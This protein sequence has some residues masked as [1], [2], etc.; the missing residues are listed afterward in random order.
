MSIF[1]IIVCII[2]GLGAGF[3]TGTIGLSAA[4]IITPMLV[5]FLGYPAYQ[6]VAISLASDVLASAISAYTYSKNDNINYKTA[7]LML[8]AILIATTVGSW[9]SS[10]FPSYALGNF[11]VMTTL[12]I[13]LNFIYSPLQYF[14]NPYKN[15]NDSPKFRNYKIIAAGIYV[16]L[17]CGILGGGGGM[18][19]LFVF[20]HLFGYNLKL[21]V[22]TSTFIMT[23]TA[24]MGSISHMAI[25][26]VPHKGALVICIITT[27]IGA[28]YASRFANKSNDNQVR[29]MT[30]QILS[31]LGTVMIMINLFF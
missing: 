3:S 24:L 18:I 5:T 23:F 30:G 15:Q 7:V 16:G 22:G 4:T 29:K 2:A 11:A 19:M 12:I 31:V 13:G 20:T 14:N 8:N 26:G 6:A 17:N 10:Y 27:L 1:S 28:K 25:G 9:I 21:S